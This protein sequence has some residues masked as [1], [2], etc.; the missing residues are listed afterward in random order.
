[1]GIRGQ[2]VHGGALQQPARDGLRLLA[3]VSGEC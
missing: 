3:P 2:N 1:V